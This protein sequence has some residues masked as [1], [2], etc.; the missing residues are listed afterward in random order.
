VHQVPIA[1]H[2][3]DSE[4]LGHRRHH[5]AIDQL[6]AA[7]SKWQKHRRPRIGDAGPSSQV[8]LHDFDE[9]TVAQAQIVVADA[10]A[11]RQQAVSELQRLQVNIASNVLEP[12]HSV[13][14][15]ALQ[16]Q[17]FQAALGLVRCQSATHIAGLRDMM[18]E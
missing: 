18:D 8:T 13:A 1:R 16:L 6:H 11:A 12:F 17:C 9:R 4:V 2:A 3:I 14:C 5:H 10:L 15:S 7:Q